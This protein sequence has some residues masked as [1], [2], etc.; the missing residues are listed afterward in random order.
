LC[1]PRAGRRHLDRR[2][3]DVER[4]RQARRPRDPHRDGRPGLRVGDR[5]RERRIVAAREPR[6]L[7]EQVGREGEGALLR[8][9]SAGSEPCREVDQVVIVGV[10]DEVPGRD[11]RER[12]EHADHAVGLIEAV[13]LIDLDVDEQHAVRHQALR[14]TRPEGLVDLED[15]N[16]LGQAA[17]ERRLGQDRGGDALREVRSAGIGEDIHVVRPHDRGEHLRRGRLAVRSGDERDHPTAGARPR[18]AGSAAPSAA[19]RDPGRPEPAAAEACQT[20][21]RTTDEHR[22]RCA[23]ALGG[24][25]GLLEVVAQRL[26]AGRV[27][28]LGHR[29]RLDLA[30]ALTRDAEGVADLVEGLRHPSPRPK[31]MRITPA[32]RSDS[33][34]SR[35]SSCFCSIVKPDRVGRD[36]GLGVLDEV[37]ELAVAVLAE[38]VC[39]E[40]GSR[41]YFCTSMTFSGVMSSS[42]LSSSGVGS[43]PRSCSI[44]RCTRASLL[45]TST[46]CTGMRMV[47]AWSAMARVIAWRIHQVA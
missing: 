37:A 18:A 11:A 6:R 29:L 19:R 4:G 39:S 34:S 23:H 13:Q 8:C 31:R 14:E 10:D 36:D 2:A 1:S 28:Q 25:A 46:M 35:L 27:A 41:P 26:R 32:S 40:I 47:R 20:A 30:D 12:L 45:M 7:G 44:W 16:L 33:E 24:L 22:E 15:R 43:R 42:R 21:D 38:G 17:V 5:A 3:V 9:A